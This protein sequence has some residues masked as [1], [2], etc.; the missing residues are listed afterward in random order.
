MAGIVTG[1]GGIGLY[2]SNGALV[3][4]SGKIGITTSNPHDTYFGVDP[5]GN[6][7]T[8][9]LV[10]GNFWSQD[11]VAIPS[12]CDLPNACGEYGVCSNNQC[13]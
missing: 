2:K 9:V 4:T 3:W 7:K 12:L 10:K 8:Y 13:T 1:V 5:D 11:F 6:L